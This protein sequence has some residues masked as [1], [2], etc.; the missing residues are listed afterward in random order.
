MLLQDF[1][2]KIIRRN[3]LNFKTNAAIINVNQDDALLSICWDCHTDSEDFKKSYQL[4][5]DLTHRFM[6]NKWLID[7]RNVAF[8]NIENQNWIVRSIAPQLHPHNMHKVARVVL[9]EPLA[10]LTSYNVV[11]KITSLPELA[12]KLDWEIFTD[13]DHALFWLNY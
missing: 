1:E 10:M 6:I 9:D 7:A 3:S 8:L 11:D 12:C 5:V 13:F 2:T 4:A